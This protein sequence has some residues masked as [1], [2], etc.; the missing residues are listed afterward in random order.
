[1]IDITLQNFQAELVEASLQQPVLLDIWAPWCAPCKAL[2]PVL[3]RLEVAYG[4]RFRL[5]KLNSDEVPEL[6]SQLSQMF[7]VRSIPF[8]VLFAQG[9]PVDGFVGALPESEIRSFLDRHVP[10]ADA[11][12]A[13]DELAQAQA[14][15][16]DPALD[17]E[18]SHEALEKLQH[19]VERQPDNHD[20]RAQW[21]QALVQAC[22]LALA[23]QALQDA[24]PQFTPHKRLAALSLWL[25]AREAAPSLRSCD[26]L[27]QAIE[28]N[29]RDF[30]ARYEL[31]QSLFSRD[32]FTAAM[33]E[34]LE[35]LMRD[36]SWSEELARKT[37]VAILEVMT[38]A[39]EAKA[40]AGTPATASPTPAAPGS[41]LEIAGRIQTAPADPLI[42]SYRRKLSMVLF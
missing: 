21:V 32:E 34:L 30:Q 27:R 7:G 35:I 26:A 29:K 31:A 24:P 37:Y 15:L 20:A 10:S 19:A 11:L 6:A 4:G 41:K 40:A 1:M 23:R 25:Q 28:S 2:G 36:K 18:S 38:P 5:A 8:C 17:S 33:D 9:Q 39:P 3:D 14:L 22:Q 42:D 16:A 13:E 12:A